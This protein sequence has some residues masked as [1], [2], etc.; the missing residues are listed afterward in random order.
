M[1]RYCQNHCIFFNHVAS[2]KYFIFLTSYKIKSG[3]LV[4]ILLILQDS[5]EM[6]SCRPSEV[7]KIITGQSQGGN[8]ENFLG[9]TQISQCTQATSVVFVHIKD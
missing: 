5:L 4:Q 1:I 2:R 7:V 9:E 8:Q 6:F 3:T